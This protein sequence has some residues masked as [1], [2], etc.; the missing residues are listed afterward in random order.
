MPGQPGD[1]GPV[2]TPG[3]PGQDGPCGEDGDKGE[4]GPPGKRGHPG[5]MGGFILTKHRFNLLFQIESEI[6]F[7]VRLNKSQVVQKDQSAY[8]MGSPWSPTRSETKLCPLTLV[9]SEN[10]KISAR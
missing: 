7:V 5:S 4:A 9:S 1:D 2:G 10:I 3:I 6:C 8:G